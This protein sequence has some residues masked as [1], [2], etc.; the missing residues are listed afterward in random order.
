MSGRWGSRLRRT[1]ATTAALG[2]VAV[3][4]LAACGG[5][6][7]TATTSPGTAAAPGQ[8]EA[9]LPAPAVAGTLAFA[10]VTSTARRRL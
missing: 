8:S 6:R 5:S 2:A 7:P 10:R 3:L 9:F 4:V 1:A